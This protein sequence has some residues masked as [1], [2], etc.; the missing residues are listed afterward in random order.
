MRAIGVDPFDEAAHLGLV[1]P[2]A[3]SRRHGE[4][5]RAYQVY[6]ARMRELE[7]RAGAVPRG[8]GA[9][10]VVRISKSS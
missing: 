6:A 8:R 5:R 10:R 2:F 4:A 3:A 9:D 1:R 7:R